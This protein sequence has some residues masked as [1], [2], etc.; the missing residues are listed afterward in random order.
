MANGKSWSMDCI[1]LLE[2]LHMLK[3]LGG[4][5]A[6]F[7]IGLL[8]APAAGEETRRELANKAREAAE[9]PQ[10]KANELLDA[11]PDKA[12]QVAADAARQAAE[13]A[14]AKVRDKTGLQPTGSES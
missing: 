11:V 3:F 13:E 7:G 12:A 5:A 14:V 1:P 2:V 4:L 9:Y 8:I 10:R 6:G